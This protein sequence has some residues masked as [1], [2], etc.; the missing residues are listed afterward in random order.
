MIVLAM[1][2]YIGYTISAPTW[3]WWCWGFLAA[4]QFIKLLYRMYKIGKKEN[5]N[6]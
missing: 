5:K 3:Y 1:L 4:Y 6:G 2:F